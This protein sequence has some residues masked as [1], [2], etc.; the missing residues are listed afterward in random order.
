MLKGYIRQVAKPEGCIACG[1][2]HYEAMFYVS[3]AIECFDSNAPTAW[4]EAEEGK[5]TLALRLL[6]KKT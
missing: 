1:H 5:G 6:G 3:H 2:L 4:E